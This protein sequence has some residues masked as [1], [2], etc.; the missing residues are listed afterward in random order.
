MTREAW[1][2][3]DTYEPFMGRWSRLLADEVLTWLAPSPGE[4]WLD[5]GC[6]TGALSEAILTRTAPSAITG[7]DPSA[8]YVEAARRRLPDRRVR[9]EVGDAT[10]LPVADASVDHAASGLVLNFVPE[11]DVALREV[12]R[13]LVPGGRVTAYVWD[14]AAG[15]EMLRHFW[16]AAA[17]TDPASRDLDEGERF[18]VCRP[19]GLRQ[20]FDDAGLHSLRDGSAGITMAF[21]DVDDYWLPFL[22]GQ[23]PASAY[24]ASLDDA[25]R[26]RLRSDLLPRLAPDPQTPITLHARA[27]VRHG[28]L[29]LTLTW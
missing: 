14:Y 29:G 3:A 13:T 27:W 18:A 9:V 12:R 20:L 11:P 21:R 6:G 17:A 24:C 5:V 15:M 2:S 25:G 23:G 7:V 1:T 26:E 16:D 22:G 8:A 10:S 4:R 28:S 19:G